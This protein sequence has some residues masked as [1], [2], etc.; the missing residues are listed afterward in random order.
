[1]QNTVDFDSHFGKANVFDI[2]KP[3]TG[4]VSDP[5]GLVDWE[6]DVETIGERT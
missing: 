3:S 5:D 1:M 4:T 2:E 6:H